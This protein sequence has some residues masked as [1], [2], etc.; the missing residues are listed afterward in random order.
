MDKKIALA[1]VAGITTGIAIFLLSKV[2]KEK[3][4]AGPTD[5]NSVTNPKRTYSH[6]YTL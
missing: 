4:S 2:K 1:L 5:E 3:K 6:E